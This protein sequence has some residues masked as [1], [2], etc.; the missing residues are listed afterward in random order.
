[1]FPSYRCRLESCSL[2]RSMSE[3]LAD[4]ILPA[5][6]NPAMEVMTY[7]VAMEFPRPL[8]AASSFSIPIR[9]RVPL[10]Q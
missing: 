6:S 7:G 8:R 10:T 5:E 2:C 4:P 1:M 9:G 3:C